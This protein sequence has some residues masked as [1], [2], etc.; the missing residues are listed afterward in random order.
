MI[1][2]KTGSNA[3]PIAGFI[4]HGNWT[5]SPKYIRLLTYRKNLLFPVVLNN[6]P[7]EDINS[8]ARGGF[9]FSDNADFLVA[10]SSATGVNSFRVY[11]RSGIT[12]TALTV[13]GW[14]SNDRS[15]SVSI[16]PSGEYIS[17]SNKIYHNNSGSL[18]LL[19]GAAGAYNAL[20]PN[21]LFLAKNDIPTTTY[22]IQIMKRS[23]FGNSASFANHQFISLST[24]SN[25]SPQALRFS[26]NGEYLAVGNNLAPRLRIYKYNPGTD[27]FDPLNQPPS[28]GV[29]PTPEVLHI[30]WAFDDSFVSATA[31]NSSFLYERSGDSF[32]HR[33]TI[34][35]SY[36]Y[37]GGFHPSGNFFIT[38][39]GNIYRKITAS[40]WQYMSSVNSFPTSPG[41]PSVF[42]S[43]GPSTFSPLI[44]S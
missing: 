37:G 19:T 32:T 41:T 21:G 40:N 22:G 36:N 18:A 14:T 24:N 30:A 13:P 28:G 12:F 10:G 39:G 20:S 1:A 31:P 23:G 27:Q 7:N 25:A 38:G 11:S 15:F 16:T 43:F 34:T 6:Q 2:T 9:E 8:E 5:P 29:Q 3:G 42:P 33:A 44:T 35:N 17:T 26:R 4:A